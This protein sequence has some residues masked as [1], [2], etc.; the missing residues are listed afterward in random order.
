[1]PQGFDGVEALYDVPPC[2]TGCPGSSGPAAWAPDHP[3]L[4]FHGDRLFVHVD[5]YQ[6]R[7]AYEASL[8]AYY[9]DD[10]DLGRRLTDELLARGDSPV[11]GGASAAT[12]ERIPVQTGERP[13]ETV[14][15]AAGSDLGPPCRPP[16]EYHTAVGIHRR[17]PAGSTRAQVPSP[18]LWAIR[19]M[20][21]TRRATEQPPP[22]HPDEHT[23]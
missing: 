12:S 17:V 19:S 8:A 3:G 18:R 5:V 7:M 9:L 10:L 11:P 2:A 13:I 20:Q 16:F 15:E 22:P 23:R 6:W 21:P 4:G 1:V 14:P